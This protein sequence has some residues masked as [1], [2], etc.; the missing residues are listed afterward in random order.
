MEGLYESKRA[1]LEW[2]SQADKQDSNANQV[3]LVLM[4]KKLFEIIIFQF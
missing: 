3:K 4:G 2:M 1:N